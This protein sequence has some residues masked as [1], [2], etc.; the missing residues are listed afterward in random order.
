[1]RVAALL[2]LSLALSLPAPADGEVLRFKRLDGGDVN[3]SV[4][5]PPGAG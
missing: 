5:R 4:D 3:A 2:A 1:M